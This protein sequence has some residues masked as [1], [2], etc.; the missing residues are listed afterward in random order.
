MINACESVCPFPPWVTP[1]A[2]N[3]WDFGSWG[4]ITAERTGLESIAKKVSY[5]QCAVL[6]TID[7]NEFQISDLVK[8]SAS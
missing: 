2:K 1:Q 6:E 8:A 5:L 4:A 3:I 7:I